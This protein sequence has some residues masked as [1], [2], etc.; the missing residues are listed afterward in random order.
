MSHVLDDLTFTQS[1]RRIRANQKAPLY[2]LLVNTA[3]RQ[4]PV[5]K[6]QSTLDITPRNSGSHFVYQGA[7]EFHRSINYETDQ[8]SYERNK[9]VK[10]LL[11]F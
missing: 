8:L 7:A 6:I 4:N 5:F 1:H 2:M 11:R 9:I 3:L 10:E